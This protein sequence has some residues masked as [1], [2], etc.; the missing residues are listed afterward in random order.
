MDFNEIEPRSKIVIIVTNGSDLQ[1]RFMTKVMRNMGTYLLAIPFKH[2]GLRINFKGK[3]VKIHM[4]VRD[5]EGALWSFRSCHISTAKKDG[6]VYHRIDSGMVHG[7]ENRRGGR[8]FHLWEPGIFHISSLVDPLFTTMKDV[9]PVG[10]S[11]VVDSKKKASVKEGD[12]VEAH[13][14]NKDGEE[15]ILE[16]I[17]VR[18][19]VLEKYTIYGCKMDNPSDAVQRFIKYLEKKNIIV[20]AEL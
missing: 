1:A 17:M 2:K 16:G 9:G 11:F 12:M 13:I 3:N 8:R 15:L 6:L 10:F 4:E 19:E 20:D 18:T 14:K 5:S 7:I